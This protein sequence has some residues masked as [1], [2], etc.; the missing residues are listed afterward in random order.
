MF[1]QQKK[2]KIGYGNAQS[3]HTSNY[4]ALELPALLYVFDE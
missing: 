1:I 2:G 3:N 4:N